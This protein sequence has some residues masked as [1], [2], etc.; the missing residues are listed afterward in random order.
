MPKIKP[1]KKGP[2]VIKAKTRNDPDPKTQN[3]QW[4]LMD[5]KELPSSVTGVVKYL[6][7]NQAW[8]IEQAAL[9]G[10]MYCNM[11][12][13]NYMGAN[14]SRMRSKSNFPADRPTYNVVQSCIDT[15]VSRMIQ[16][17]PK[18][19][20]LT[21]GGNYKQQ[22][23][24]KDLNKFI[25]G[26]FYQCRV[27]EKRERNLRNSCTFGDGL[28]KVF[29]TDD[30]KV[31][32]EEVLATEVY[33]DD[34]DGKYG[35]PQNMYQLELINRD[36]AAGM[37]PD[38]RAAIYK[39]PPAYFDTTTESQDSVTSQIMIVE[40]WH[41]KSA[42]KASDGRHV[43]TIDGAVLLDEDWDDDEFPFVKMAY[44]PAPIGYWSQGM[45]ERLMGLQVSINQ[46][47]YT[48][49]AGLHL[50]AIPIW[51]I[52]DGSKV[53][54]AHMNNQIG[55]LVRYQGTPPTLHSAQVFPPEI[56]QQL[57]RYINM[58]FQQEGISQ[59]AATSQKPSGLNSGKAL[60]EYDD[61]Q[62]DR[63]AALA[64]RDEK[65]MLDLADRMFKMARKIAQREGEYQTIYPGKNGVDR[66]DLPEMTDEDDFVIQAYPI[67]GYSKN[68]PQRKEQI[69]EDMQAGLLDPDEG[70]RLLD[71]PDIKQ[72]TDLQNAPEERILKILDEIVDE[73]EYTPPDPFMDLQK[74]KKLCVQYYNKFLQE[75]LEEDKAQMLRT[76]STQI[77]T[78]LQAA[79]QPPPMDPMAQAGG[80]GPQAVPAAPPVSPML[81]NA[82][83]A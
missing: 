7:D 18:P 59:L 16:A 52:E 82:P 34:A 72:T 64:Q 46:L 57:E 29:E 65:F 69:V 50:C 15:L 55:H 35:D 28:M 5:K 68:P 26:E 42:K 45:P 13:W 56:Y 37:Y 11:P 53:V 30:H 4:W 70:R 77:D 38:K 81:P 79:Q 41:K 24:A 66:I 62:T 21:N 23:L 10:R 33:V 61:I 3:S 14:F 19:M 63:F 47:L 31:G 48:Q 78:M 9:H 43:I 39:A 75:E 40:G 76:F 60:R 74:A 6:K 20:F 83:Q 2:E 51:M 71:F 58:A 27:Y 32:V 49:H 22:K 73:G 36:I 17:K 1:F 25:E 12:I 67:S 8:R 80:G 54:S 44:A